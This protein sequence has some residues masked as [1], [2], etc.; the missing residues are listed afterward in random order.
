M[1]ALILL[2]IIIVTILLGK[3]ALSEGRRVEQQKKFIK[4]PDNYGKKIKND[5]K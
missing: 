1:E 5:R 3:Y 4:N 2:G